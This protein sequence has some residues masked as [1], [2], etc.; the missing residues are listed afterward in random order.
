MLHMT[1]ERALVI[2]HG[3]LNFSVL[4]AGKISTKRRLNQ[5]NLPLILTQIFLLIELAVSALTIFLSSSDV[6]HN[7]DLARISSM[8]ILSSELV[9]SF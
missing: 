6:G 1:G 8:S 4:F 5:R 2:G 3:F 7:P 9:S